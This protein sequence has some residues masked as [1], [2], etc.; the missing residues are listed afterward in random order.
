MKLSDNYIR[1]I[2]N[3][4]GFSARAYYEGVKWTIGYGNTYY[5]NGTPVKK[6]DVIS[7]ARAEELFMNILNDFSRGV[8]N[9]LKVPVN[10]NQFDAL[11]SFAYN[12]GIGAFRKSTLLKKVNKNPDDPT[13]REEFLRWKY[14]GGRIL[15]GLIRRRQVEAN[16]Y[17]NKSILTTNEVSDWLTEILKIFSRREDVA[18]ATGW[19]VVSSE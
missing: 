2:R 15:N 18:S 8:K 11:V 6:G 9:S 17:F 7:Q 19:D 3:F 16:H 4:E 13:I 12:V 5:E 14:S 10:Q 1:Q